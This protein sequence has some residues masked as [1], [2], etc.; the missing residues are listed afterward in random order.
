MLGGGM[1]INEVIGWNYLSA[2]LYTLEKS[3][4]FS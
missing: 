1:I 4:Q 3:K 2:R